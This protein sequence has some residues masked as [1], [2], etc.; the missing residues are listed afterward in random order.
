MGS[1]IR[2]FFSHPLVFVLGFPILLALLG[3]FVAY[4]IVRIA[5]AIGIPVLLFTFRTMMVILAWAVN[6]IPRAR[7][8][9]RA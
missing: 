3:L 5:F 7:V 6:L 4:L 9:R 2:I 1:L 8:T